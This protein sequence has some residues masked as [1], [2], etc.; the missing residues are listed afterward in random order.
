MSEWIS[1]LQYVDRTGLN[2]QSSDK[3]CFLPN[4]AGE[5]TLVLSRDRV[6]SYLHLQQSFT[7]SGLL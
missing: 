1:F 6:R 5:G 4:S 3:N 2:K 7:R